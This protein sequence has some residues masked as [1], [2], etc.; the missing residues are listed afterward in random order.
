VK[1]I[2]ALQVNFRAAK[3]L[4][5]ARSVEERSRAAGVIAQQA[6]EFLLKLLVVPSLFIGG[7]EFLQRRHQGFGDIATA[8]GSETSV[9]RARRFLVRPLR[10]GDCGCVLGSHTS[11]R[12]LFSRR[13]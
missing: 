10:P 12:N 6:I 2:F 4:G 13:R 11:P 5:K 1:K 3:L 9:N 7:F 8:I